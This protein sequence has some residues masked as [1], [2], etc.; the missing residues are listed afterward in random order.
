VSL[1][2]KGEIDAVAASAAKAAVPRTSEKRAATT[3]T[4]ERTAKR[5]RRRSEKSGEKIIGVP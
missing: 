4:L 2:I 3:A 1:L 5:A